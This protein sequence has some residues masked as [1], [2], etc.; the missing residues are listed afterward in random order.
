MI[1]RRCLTTSFGL[2][3]VATLA[4]DLPGFAGALA[5]TPRKLKVEPP[6][7]PWTRLG[8]VQRNGGVLNYA[9]IGPKEST[10]PPIVLLHKLGGWLSDWRFVAPALAE[11][12]RVI[13]FDLPGHGGSEWAAP[14]P[15]IQTLGESAAALVGAWDEMGI[16]QVDLVGTSLGGCASVQ[17]AASWPEKVR[18]L[19]VV[20][21]A[22]N[23][24][25]DLA[26]IKANI[27]LKQTGLYDAKGMPTPTAPELLNQVFGIINT[28]P[29]AAEGDRSRQAAGLWIQP[30]ERGVGL[31]DFPSLLRRVQA[32]TLL[33][34]GELDKAYKKFIPSA[35]AALP[36]AD[37]QYVPKA[38]AFVMQDNPD[39][40]SQIL[41]K[42][43]NGA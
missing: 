26:F 2:G 40:T 14:P 34:Y 15:Y 11:G 18:K 33:L 27:D 6:K 23:V 25:H 16:P 10:Q 1:S 36:A 3:A 19:A 24:G 30:S 39:G 42:F 20:S 43:L 17:L 7:G 35:K 9:E 28:V 5:A 38:G 31:A 4:S 21:S 8:Q 29:I 37:V 41:R 22:L 12:R 13:A 32:P